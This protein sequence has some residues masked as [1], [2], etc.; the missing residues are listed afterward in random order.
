MKKGWLVVISLV[1]AIALLGAVGCAAVEREITPAVA[2][3]C[4]SPPPVFYSRLAPVYDFPIH[5]F[6]PSAY[7]DPGAE[8]K[9][10]KLEFTIPGTVFELGEKTVVHMW[11]TNTGNRPIR[12]YHGDPLAWVVFEDERGLKW[13]PARG[14]V[15]ILVIGE[16][17]PNQPHPGRKERIILQ[18]GSPIAG[19]IPRYTL[20]PGTYTLHVFADITFSDPAGDGTNGVRIW[21]PPVQIEISESTDEERG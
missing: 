13:I 1:A 17:E 9:D 11:L 4:T 8:V 5:L 12:C 19:I 16:L 2:A 20:E 7:Y 10:I 3:E 18:A 21:A 14:F 6:G 15:A